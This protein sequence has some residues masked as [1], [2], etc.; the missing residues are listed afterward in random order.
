MP[1]GWYPLSQSTSEYTHNGTHTNE[2]HSVYSGKIAP[3]PSYYCPSLLHQPYLTTCAVLYGC[4]NHSIGEDVSGAWGDPQSTEEIWYIHCT[5]GALAP[6]A[7]KS[8]S[9][10][11]ACY[12]TLHQFSHDHHQTSTTLIDWSLLKDFITCDMRPLPSK[13]NQWL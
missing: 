1:G 13:I 8:T 2:D 7:G 12:Y 10:S 6:L 4:E 9:A 3:T 5:S 11:V